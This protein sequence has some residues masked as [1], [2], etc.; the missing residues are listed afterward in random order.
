MICYIDQN[1]LKGHRFS[2]KCFAAQQFSTLIMTRNV[3]WASD[4]HFRISCDS[5]L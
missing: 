2:Q 5:I 4:Q 1:S 3:S